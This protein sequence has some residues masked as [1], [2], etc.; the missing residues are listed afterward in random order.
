M[1]TPDGA[2]CPPRAAVRRFFA[3]IEDG[4]LFRDRGLEQ[5]IKSKRIPDTE[6]IS[7]RIA[8]EAESEGK[9]DLPRRGD[10]VGSARIDQVAR[11]LGAEKIGDILDEDVGT[12]DRALDDD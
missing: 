7:G 5:T 9:V 8:V 1:P 3:R 12:A 4:W 11:T 2:R 10:A 6:E